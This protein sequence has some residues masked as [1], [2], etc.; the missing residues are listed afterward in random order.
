MWSLALFAENMQRCAAFGPRQL[1]GLVDT[2]RTGCEFGLDFEVAP[3]VRAYLQGTLGL[4]RP[5]SLSRVTSLASNLLLVALINAAP[6][7]DRYMRELEQW[8]DFLLDFYFQESY[9]STPTQPDIATEESEMT[10]NDVKEET[11][12]DQ[13][14]STSNQEDAKEEEEKE[15]ETVGELDISTTL[16]AFRKQKLFNTNGSKIDVNSPKREEKVHN[17]FFFLPTRLIITFSVIL[18]T[19]M[20]PC[21]KEPL[22]HGFYY[23]PLSSCCRNFKKILNRIFASFGTS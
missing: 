2:L 21:R 17:C 15:E 13:M 8:L 14:S 1:A 16:E 19:L 3:D 4:S 20:V 9:G 7:S 5:P 11:S 12:K 18:I 10:T 6:F 23:F 22:Y